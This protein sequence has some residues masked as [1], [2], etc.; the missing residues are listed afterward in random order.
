MDMHIHTR[1]CCLL[2]QRQ[3]LTSKESLISVEKKHE[4]THP[5]NTDSHTGKRTHADTH[6]CTLKRSRSTNSTLLLSS[7]TKGETNDTYCSVETPSKLSSCGI[8]QSEALSTHKHLKYEPGHIMHSQ[9]HVDEYILTSLFYLYV[10]CFY[11]NVIECDSQR[12]FSACRFTFSH[13]ESARTREVNRTSWLWRKAALHFG[14][15][16]WKPVQRQEAYFCSISVLS[17]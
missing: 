8:F 3:F 14:Q 17:S 9:K 1:T 10:V 5:Q 12:S 13:C 11:F 15:F 16:T 2:A 7:L 4:H 6:W